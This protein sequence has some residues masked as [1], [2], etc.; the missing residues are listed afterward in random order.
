LYR[1]LGYDYD[2]SKPWYGIPADI[3]V[4]GVSDEERTKQTEILEEKGRIPFIDYPL[5][6]R[7]CGE[8]RPEM[9]SVPNEE[10]EKYIEPRLRGD[11]LCL[12]CYALIKLLVDT[13]GTLGYVPSGIEGKEYAC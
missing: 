12:R 7:K 13:N 8:V 5:I 6:C 1:L 3:F 4:N 11:V 10:W 2:P 9:F